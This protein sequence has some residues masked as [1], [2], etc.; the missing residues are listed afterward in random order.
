MKDFSR[1]ILNLIQDLLALTQKGILNQ[2][3]N[4][5]IQSPKP[6]SHFSRLSFHSKQ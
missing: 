5:Y 1:F 2:V 6:T 3:Q 4:D